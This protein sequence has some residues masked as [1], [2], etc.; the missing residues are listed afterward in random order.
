MMAIGTHRVFALLWAVLVLNVTISSASPLSHTEARALAGAVVGRL[1]ARANPTGSYTPSTAVCP[2]TP[3]GSQYTGFIRS[4]IDNAVSPNE[5]DYINRH[6]QATQQSW[7][8]W[9]SNAAPGPN[10]NTDQGIAGGVTNYTSDLSRLPRIGIALSGGGYRAMING[11]GF[12]QGLDARNST[13]QQRGTAGILQQSLYVA[14]LSGGSWAVGGLA[15]NDWPE[16]QTLKDQT[17]NLNENLIAPSDGA[18]SFY[19]DI[20]ADVAGKRIAGYPTGIVDYWGRALSYH[21]VN[22]TYPSEG[23]ATTFGDIRNTSNFQSFSYPL[24]LVVADE[25]EPGQLLIDGN[26]TIYEFSPYEFG[27]YGSDVAAFVPIDILGTNLL[28]GVSAQDNSQ[29][30]YG[31][32]NF[33]WVVGT[34]ST[35]FNELFNML[36]TSDG[37][38]VIKDALESILGDV[39]SDQNDVSVLPNPFR[40]YDTN[41]PNNT[42]SGLTNITMVD[43]GEDDQNIPVNTLLLPERRL[44]L[45]LAVDNSADV[46][47]FPNGTALHETYLRY[48]DYAQFNTVAMPVIPAPTTF[49]NRGLN[50]RPTF[51]GCNVTNESIIN[52]ASATNGTVPPIIAYMPNYPYSTLSNTSTYQLQYN[53]SEAQ[54]LLDNAVNVATLGGE[55]ISSSLSWST[56]LACAALERGFVRSNTLRPTVCT[57]CLQTFCWDGITNDTQPSNPYS[58]PIGVPEFVSSGGARQVSPLFTGGNGSNVDMSG[59]SSGGGQGS[60]NEGFKHAPFNILATTISVFIAMTSAMLL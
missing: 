29:C 25:R 15:I 53:D 18:I 49:I 51:F 50:T 34:S 26:T 47:D 13:A 46:T 23:Q 8:E 41:N 57:Q 60:S 43:G 3:S 27:S 14:G 38:S 16:V 42:I 6:L 2:P 24:P 32:D 9:L 30:T 10:L 4:T 59:S 28:N 20:V 31:F 56:C 1:Q 44:D 36:I 35:L 55:A 21:L 37:D 17:W 58:P 40:G 52:L 7:S 39:S 33:G 11:A 22:S 12:L 48:R 5:T 45:I 54:A 19:A